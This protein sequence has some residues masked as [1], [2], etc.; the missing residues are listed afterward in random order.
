MEAKNN[1]NQLIEPI[2]QKDF[3]YIIE[4]V[5]NN[6]EIGIKL[7]LSSSNPE[8]TQI[9]SLKE[10]FIKYYISDDLDLLNL[11]LENEN[12]EIIPETNAADYE[13]FYN[14]D[15]ILNDKEVLKTIAPIIE[16]NILLSQDQ[17]YYYYNHNNIDL[18]ID[19]DYIYYNDYDTGE[20]YK[21]FIMQ[22]IT[23]YLE[24]S[25]TD[26]IS[27]LD[28][29]HENILNGER[30]FYNICCYDSKR[31]QYNLTIGI[32]QLL[33]EFIDYDSY[34]IRYIISD[35]I[36]NGY[37]LHQYQT[38]IQTINNQYQYYNNICNTNITPPQEAIQSLLY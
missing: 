12:G 11:L 35:I 3:I 28:F 25:E 23:E 9:I 13:Y 32:I 36:T 33:T 8:Q 5:S 18:F 34:N 31:N 27:N 1:I 21:N 37:D 4:N 16:Q 24:I 22:L 38:A 19:D 20:D 10:Y 14:L 30:D 26:F 2:Q 7:Q 29:I 6:E 17:A 15:E